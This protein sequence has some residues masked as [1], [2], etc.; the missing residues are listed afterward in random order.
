MTSSLSSC[1]DSRGVGSRVSS[2]DYDSSL[3]P[4]DVIRPLSDAAPHLSLSRD[5]KSTEYGH[6]TEN[7]YKVPK[8]VVR[9]YILLL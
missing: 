6:D 9:I 3:P 8:N 7:I 4:R 1:E 2:K 5:L